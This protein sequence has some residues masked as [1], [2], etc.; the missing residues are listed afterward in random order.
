MA[1]Q[2]AAKKALHELIK[3]EDLKNK[4]RITSLMLYTPH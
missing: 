3:Q 4:G 1:D 2:V